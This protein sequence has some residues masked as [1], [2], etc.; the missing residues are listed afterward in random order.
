[1]SRALTDQAELI[2]TVVSNF[3]CMTVTQ[4]EKL[5]GEEIAKKNISFLIL[6]N[7]IRTNDDNTVLYTTNK[8]KVDTNMLD[9]LWVAIGRATDKDGNFNRESLMEAF[10][11]NPTQ[12]SMIYNNMLYYITAVTEANAGSVIPFLIDRFKKN[13]PSGKSDGLEYIFVVRSEDLIDYILDFGIELP[14]RIVLIEG[15]TTENPKVRYLK[16]K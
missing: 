12:I 7:Y 10:Q 15:N 11:Y 6:K 16:T 1:M 5:L 8:P 4:A 13:N 9:C 2:N 3:G 14:F